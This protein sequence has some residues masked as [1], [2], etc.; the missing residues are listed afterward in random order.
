MSTKESKAN[1]KW[2]LCPHHPGVKYKLFWEE[3]LNNK[4]DDKL[5]EF[6][7]SFSNF[8]KVWIDRTV[9]G[10]ESCVYRYWASRFIVYSVC[11]RFI[12]LK[13]RQ[14][15]AAARKAIHAGRNK[16]TELLL[17]RVECRSLSTHW[18]VFFPPK[19]LFFSSFFCETNFF[20]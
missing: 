16:C 12:Y 15:W 8:K 1:S 2:L 18:L 14:G 4:I 6:F 7:L 9:M 11:M 10:T 19:T 20:F 13:A 3:D 17:N 5:F